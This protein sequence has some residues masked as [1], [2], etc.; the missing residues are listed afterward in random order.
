MNSSIYLSREKNSP[1]VP[2]QPR[3]RR[4][5][6]AA[7]AVLTIMLGSLLAFSLTQN[8][9]VK[10]SQAFDP[11]QFVMCN[12]LPKPFPTFYQWSQTSELQFNFFSKSAISSGYDRVDNGIL[13]GIL[14]SVNSI[15]L[16]K[17]PNGSAPP[18]IAALQKEDGL[19]S[20]VTNI[21]RLRNDT[22]LGTDIDGEAPSG[23]LT[24][25][26][27]GNFVYN[28]FDLWGVGGLDFTG[29]S[30]EW[31]YIVVNACDSSAPAA[32]YQVNDYYNDRL[33]PLS[34]WDNISSSTDP[35]TEQFSKGF[36][37]RFL[38]ASEVN[39][40]NV[41]F[42]IT[43][44][45]VVMTVGLISLS[46]ANISSVLGLTKIV[47]GAGANGGGG[48]YSNLHNELFLPLV[49]L[50][51][52]ATAVRMIYVGIIQRQFREALVDLVRSI[53]LF[54]VA[55]IVA[56]N[57]PFWTSIPNN[58]GVVGESLVASALN[59][60]EPTGANNLCYSTAGNQV[61]LFSKGTN[62]DYSSQKSLSQVLTSSELNLESSVGCNLWSNLLFKPYIQGQFGA[63]SLSQLNGGALGNKNSIWADPDNSATDDQTGLAVPHG[64]G[65]S[66]NNLGLFQISTLTNAH[67]PLGSP[68]DESKYSQ[69]VA[70]DWWRIVDVL[71][72]YNEDLAGCDTPGATLKQ[73]KS[74]QGVTSGSTSSTKVQRGAQ[75]LSD[76]PLAGWNTWNGDETGNRLYAS[77]SSVLIGT[78]AVI[79]PMFFAL[80][81]ALFG[82][83][84]TILTAFAPVFL[85]LGCWAGR[86]FNIFK[87]WA[88]LLINTIMKRIGAG[89]LVIISIT[90]VDNILNDVAGLS[91]TQELLLIVIIAW[92][93]IKVRHKIF[94][95]LSFARFSSYDLGGTAQR[96]GQIVKK[97]VK[98][99][100]DI[101][102]GAVTGGVGSK[103]HGGT[104]KGGTIA[105]AKD[106]LRNLS[107]RNQLGRSANMAYQMNSDSEQLD[108][109]LEG[110][111]CS[112]C[113]RL[114]TGSD[115]TSLYRDDVNG[116]LLCQDCFAR[117]DY[118]EAQLYIPDVNKRLRPGDVN[119]H[120]SVNSVYEDTR[121]AEVS[122][123]TTQVKVDGSPEVYNATIKDLAELIAAAAEEVDKF[124]DRRAL[125]DAHADKRQRDRSLDIQ[126]PKAIEKF[127]DKDAL[128]LAVDGGE[129][130]YIKLAY[131]GAWIARQKELD[132]TFSEILTEDDIITLVE[133]A[134]E[135]AGNNWRLRDEKVEK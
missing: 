47:D 29:Y 10:Q 35:R 15:T 89:I 67:A 50:A 82:L 81:S 68:G 91:Y 56:A 133:V 60:D 2:R 83:G 121:L 88:D 6:V 84:I 70:N 19:P 105:G 80:L 21:F 86:G 134:Q 20:N 106:E 11:V 115:V 132:P 63:N 24:T 113:G 52:I 97:G 42:D 94:N 62:V 4:W 43:K 33:Y 53:V 122:Q 111:Y 92:V 109:S 96:V 126:I 13:N 98:E 48:L 38:I 65:K 85:L 32:N 78:A 54:I 51:F 26:N 16:G 79:A 93:L 102:V 127:I 28:P 123:R 1:K 57:I 40:S 73:C 103:V 76:K 58:I 100:S 75:I 108:D 22:V 95:M 130:Q 23:S 5:P 49:Y 61:G 31:N 55:I 129:D 30:G 87:A 120:I 135:S 72:N 14:S 112:D 25:Y 71:S 45:I 118:P 59:R 41:I 116:L 39:V 66:W 46:F 125:R 117:G 131:A 124:S 119:K 110:Q 9:Q 74:Q 104:F 8:S 107:Y 128:Q 17:G 77:I 34:T 12:V 7:L 3:R 36:G 64:N 27:K 99:T 90:F 44:F 114:L 101:G 69:G 37:N 18:S